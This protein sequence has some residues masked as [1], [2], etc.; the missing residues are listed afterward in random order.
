MF[1]LKVPGLCFWARGLGLLAA[2]YMAMMYNASVTA[3]VLI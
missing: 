2:S 1:L 3:A